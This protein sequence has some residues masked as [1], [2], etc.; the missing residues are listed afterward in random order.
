MPN[1]EPIPSPLTARIK[2]LEQ[3]VA[4]LQRAQKTLS[5]SEERFQRLAD[6]AE[7]G[8]MIN[9][10][11]VIIDAN[12]ALS[13]LFGYGEDE[14]IGMPSRRLIT[15]ASYAKI[16]RHL[17]SGY[18]RPLEV[19]GLKKDGSTFICRT[20][21]KPYR[22]KGKAL[23]VVVI[24]D[25]SALKTAQLELEQSEK[26]YRAVFE[27]SGTPAIIIDYD[28][29]IAMANAKFAQLVKVP[30]AHLE[31]RRKCTDFLSSPGLA[32]AFND[33][34]HSSGGERNCAAEYESQLTT[35][36]DE[37]I[38]VVLHV[39][40][41][42]LSDPGP[43]GAPVQPMDPPKETECP[44]RGEQLIISLTDITPLK[45]VQAQLRSSAANL[46]RENIRL[47]SSLTGRHRFGG[48]IGESRAM[49]AVYEIITEAAATHASTIIY[50]ESGTGKELVARAIHDLSERGSKEFVPINCGAMPEN[51]LESELFG[52]RRGAFTGAGR[53]KSGLLDLADGGTLFLDEIGEMGL[54]MQVK[55]L[56]AI[57]GS[58]YTPIGSRQVRHSDFRIIAAT[59]RDLSQLVRQ[60]RIRKDFYYR[61]HI[62][63]IFL[64]PLRQ[65]RRDI[66]LLA[67][68]FIKI[69]APDTTD[70]PALSPEIMATLTRY[71]WPGNVRELQNVIH[72][73]IT[74]KRIDLA[75]APFDNGETPDGYFPANPGAAVPDAFSPFTPSP[76]APP[77]QSLPA[78]VA[79][80]EK[81]YLQQMLKQYAWQKGRLAA[82]LGIDRRTLYDK[83]KRYGIKPS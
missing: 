29:T 27:N 24:S 69:H 33:G 67:D 83:I 52:Y 34:I 55:L 56:R 40:R 79:E 63:P 50:G 44:D 30:P 66:P 36:D 54:N 74:L 14:V 3:E 1:P 16:Q 26:K 60:G 13:R 5:E 77:T 18:D 35:A 23:R 45:Q 78:V 59:H 12:R 39:G 8:I 53:D 20:L 17:V 81:K 10:N 47:K 49:Q 75:G 73:Y 58:G 28:M 48:L 37:V 9:D 19:L 7:D 22:Y 38:D 4:R 15:A 80:F 61:V 76:A 57:E 25:I 2:S 32:G 51:I 21:G 82:L 64:P 71:D 41:L 65:R 31:G 43:S 46:R 62:I 11:G 70:L 72:R 42:L 6:I 68:H